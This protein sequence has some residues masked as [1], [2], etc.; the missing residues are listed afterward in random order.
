ME[1]DGGPWMFPS[2]VSMIFWTALASPSPSSHK[3]VSWVVCST[4][5]ASLERGCHTSSQKGAPRGSAEM[6]PKCWRRWMVNV[7][8]LC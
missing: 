1:C 5:H 7:P 3:H 6:L 4:S 2:G 8:R